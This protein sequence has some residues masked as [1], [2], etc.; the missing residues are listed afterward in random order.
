MAILCSSKEMMAAGNFRIVTNVEIK[1]M[2]AALLGAKDRQ[3]TYL[4]NYIPAERRALAMELIRNA[5]KM[6]I[7]HFRALAR[8]VIGM[9]SLPGGATGGGEAAIWLHRQNVHL[10][11]E[12]SIK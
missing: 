10:R 4:Q 12:I 11:Q 6:A 8:L 1:L 5:L 2:A 7:P 9:W 3:R